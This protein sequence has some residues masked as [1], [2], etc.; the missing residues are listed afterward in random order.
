LPFAVSQRPR[1][2]PD[3][4]DCCHTFLLHRATRAQF[5]SRTL[6]CGAS[7]SVVAHSDVI[8]HTHTHTHTRARAHVRA[9]WSN[10]DPSC[11]LGTWRASVS[12]TRLT[13][14]PPSLLPPTLTPCAPT[15]TL[16]C[17]LESVQRPLQPL[18]V[19]CSQYT[20]LSSLSQKCAPVC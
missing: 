20:V 3:R 16:C 5:S 9:V 2:P 1:S 12:P 4:A 8:P 6:S 19:V 18:N 10:A 11:D 13:P 17:A 14:F 7:S 15:L